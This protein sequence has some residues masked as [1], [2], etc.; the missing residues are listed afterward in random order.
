VFANTMLAL[1]ERI[2]GEMPFLPNP[3]RGHNIAARIREN[4][5]SSD[6]F[7]DSLD[8]DLPSGDANTW[9]FFL[10]IFTDPEMQRRALDTLESRGFTQ[11]VPLRYFADR[12]AARE[13][14]FPRLFAPNYQG[15][16]SWTQIGP[17]YLHLLRTTNLER[18]ERQRNAMA[19]FIARDQNY[20]ELYTKEGRPYRGR[21]GFYFADEGMLWASLF[22]DLF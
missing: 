1:L 11:P 3:L 4:Y 21:A 2:L 22:L 7:R 17:I 16:T 9:P 12:L 18:M 13:L 14:R 10:R 8:N 6:F 5:W 19:E 15:D 20:L